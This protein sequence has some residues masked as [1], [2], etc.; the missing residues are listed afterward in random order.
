MGIPSYFSHFV[1]QHRKIIK[2]IKL[3]NKP[4]DNLYLDCNAFIYDGVNSDRTNM[5]EDKLIEFVCDKLIY[6]INL[7]KPN[8]KVFI[9]FDGV[10]P[11]AKLMQQRKRRYLSWFQSNYISEQLGLGPGTGPSPASWNTSAITPG[12]LFMDK[13]SEKIKTRFNNAKEFGLEQFIISCSDEVGE[14]EH[15]IFSYIRE[16]SSYHHDTN[17][18]IYGL[19]ADLIMLTLTHLAISNN[20]YLFRETPEFIKRIDNTLNPNELYLLDI[21]EFGKKIINDFTGAQMA[22]A[23]FKNEDNINKIYDYIFIF[24]LLG[25]DFMPHFPALN[26]RTNGIDLLLNAYKQTIHS[27]NLFLTNNNHNNNHNN[28]QINWKNLRIFIEYLSISELTYIKKEYSTRD[29]KY[30]HNHQSKAHLKSEKELETKLL[31]LPMTDR[32]Y[33]KYINPNET[34]WETRYYRVLFD[35]PSVSEK[36]KKEICINYLEGL[37]WT[38]KYYKSDCVDWRWTYK[39]DYPPLLVDLLKYIPYFDTEYFTKNTKTPVAP[40]VQLSYVLPK[41]SLYLIPKAVSELLLKIKPEWYVDNCD[42]Q[43]AFCKYFWESHVKLPEIDINEL[44]ICLR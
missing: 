38:F 24:F 30:N 4:I 40:I 7:L 28:N 22:D 26:I 27:K 9:A 15:K 11:V 18:V 13:L 33:E 36:Q 19:D 41:Q 44:E 5:D 32:V 29:K 35:L 39:Y 8:K 25:N 43:W 6:Y 31:N 14:G 34:G 12:T 21:P 23:S 3:L 2:Q 20:L 42:F 17:T 16:N 37:E 10:A 1:R